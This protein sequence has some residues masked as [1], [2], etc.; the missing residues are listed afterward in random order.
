MEYSVQSQPRH[1]C[2]WL[3]IQ[4]RNLA[5]QAAFG[6]SGNLADAGRLPYKHATALRTSQRHIPLC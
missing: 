3:P 4:R 6:K 2:R 5:K 1:Q